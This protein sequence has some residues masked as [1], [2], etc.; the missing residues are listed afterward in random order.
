MTDETTVHQERK[1]NAVGVT[2][3]QHAAQSLSKSAFASLDKGFSISF[4]G[5][6]GKRQ[7]Q[8]FGCANRKK[9]VK[10]KIFK[11]LAWVSNL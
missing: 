9:I 3:M 10:P 8:R 11:F 5:S 7:L 1:R 2:Q 4:N 6:Y